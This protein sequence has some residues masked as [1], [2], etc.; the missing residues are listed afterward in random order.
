MTGKKKAMYVRYTLNTFWIFSIW[1]WL[2]PWMQI[3]QIQRGGQL[4]LTHH[5]VLGTTMKGR[6]VKANNGRGNDHSWGAEGRSLW[7]ETPKHMTDKEPDSQRTG[8]RTSVIQFQTWK[9]INTRQLLLWFIETRKEQGF[10]GLAKTHSD[11]P[12]GKCGFEFWIL[13]RIR[14]TE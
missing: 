10:R 4:Y 11:K 7:G 5:R 9:G 3:P 6:A 2:N 1:G 13:N 14:N 8:G 12:A